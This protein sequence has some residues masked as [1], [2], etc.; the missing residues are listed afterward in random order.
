MILFQVAQLE[1]SKQEAAAQVDEEKRKARR[2]ADLK[3]VAE[4]KLEAEIEK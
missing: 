4:T 2:A 3:K 1:R